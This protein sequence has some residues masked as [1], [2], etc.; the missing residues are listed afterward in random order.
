MTFRFRIFIFSFRAFLAL[1]CVRFISFFSRLTFAFSSFIMIVI[2]IF[3]FSHVIPIFSAIPSPS[4]SLASP[5]FPNPPFTSLYVTFIST[6][7]P[8]PIDPF[9][10]SIIFP[11]AFVYTFFLVI[12]VV[13]CFPPLMIFWIFNLLLLIFFVF[14]FIIFIA[15]VF[16]LLRVGGAFLVIIRVRVLFGLAIIIRLFSFRLR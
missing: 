11:F 9:C 12:I 15:R 10:T 13:V 4:I 7:F 3:S 6:V 1:A 14:I 5:S 16:F 8:F 2:F